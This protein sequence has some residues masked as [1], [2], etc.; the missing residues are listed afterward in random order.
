MNTP[1]ALEVSPIRIM[2]VDDSA[3]VRRTYSELLSKNPLYEVRVA[4]NMDEALELAEHFLPDLCI[5][6]YY[7]PQGN[8][9]VLTRTL[10]AQP[11]TCKTL[12]VILTEQSEVEELALAAGDDGAFAEVAAEA[13]RFALRGDNS[14][15]GNKRRLRRREQRWRKSRKTLP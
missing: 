1:Q 6:D 11:A 13:D 5:I 9:D 10:L 14:G 4:S 2:L 15:P 7:M 8:G 12:V 3:T